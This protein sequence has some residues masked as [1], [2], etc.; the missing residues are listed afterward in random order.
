ME[1]L[2]TAQ[3]SNQIIS[4]D[5]YSTTF[6]NGKTEA[7]NDIHLSNINFRE[8]RK[9]GKR[10]MKSYPKSNLPFYL[11]YTERNRCKTVNKP[12]V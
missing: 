8:R 12:N 7:E 1:S 6:L 9:E 11:S 2:A 3:A 5:F 4:L 10:S